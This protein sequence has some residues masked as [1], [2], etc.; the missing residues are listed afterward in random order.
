VSTSGVDL[1]PAIRADTGTAPASV[2]LALMLIAAPVP[3]LAL[4]FV[5]HWVWHWLAVH[6]GDV[7]PAWLAVIFAAMFGFQPFWRSSRRSKA[8]EDAAKKQ[9][10]GATDAAEEAVAAQKT[11]CRAKQRDWRTSPK[12]DWTPPNGAR[13]T[14][15]RTRAQDS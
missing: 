5:P 15:S 12:G 2:F 4:L 10:D 8:A 13:G 9:A 7:V 6:W 14:L 3:P 11:D 1:A